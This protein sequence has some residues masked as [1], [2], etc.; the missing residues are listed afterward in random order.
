VR[1]LSE[2]MDVTQLAET[3]LDVAAR[4]WHE[5]W[6]DAH[7]P[8]VPAELVHL[9]TLENFRDRLRD[10]RLHVWVMGPAA[11]PIG[12]YML[13][14]DELHQFYVAAASRGTGAA[15]TLMAD[16]EA[17]L[18]GRGVAV[19]WLACAV[20]NT[21]AAR[22]YEKSG[23]RRAGTVAHAVETGAGLFTVDVWRYEKP[24]MYNQ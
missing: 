2:V 21:R 9:R 22:F 5:G 3:Q 20:G 12:L 14:G 19:A 7:A 8:I 24:V 10:N 6:H 15:S 11:S 23:W 18:A 17:R 16:A 1:V 13:K 4:L